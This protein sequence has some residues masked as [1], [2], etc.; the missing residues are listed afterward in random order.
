MSFLKA[1]LVALNATKVAL[2]KGV[3]VTA[4]P[5]VPGATLWLVGL[6]LSRA[7]NCSST[8]A[9]RRSDTTTALPDPRVRVRDGVIWRNRVFVRP[10][11]GACPR[12]R[13]RAARRLM[14]LPQTEVLC[15]TRDRFFELS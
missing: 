12:W 10:S 6:A 13:A 2:R 9:G 5:P 11:Y 15:Q 7:S 8:A 4:V 3:L 14:R 1:T